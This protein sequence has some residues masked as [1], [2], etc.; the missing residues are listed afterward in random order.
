[1]REEGRT[2]ELEGE[3]RDYREPGNPVSEGLDSI[4]WVLGTMDF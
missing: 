2:D 3:V 1:M 4:V